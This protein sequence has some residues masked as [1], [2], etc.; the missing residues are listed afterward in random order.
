VGIDPHIAERGRESHFGLQGMRERATRIGAQL[1]VL[2]SPDSG[3]EVTL[4][5]PGRVVFR[6]AARSRFSRTKHLFS[7]T[8]YFG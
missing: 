5:V 7:R 2:T 8:N 3:T 6:S 1:T 4:I